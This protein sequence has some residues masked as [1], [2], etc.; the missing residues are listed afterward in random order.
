MRIVG[1]FVLLTM[2][3]A[4]RPSRVVNK[5]LFSTRFQCCGIQRWKSIISTRHQW[6][7]CDVTAAA[8]ADR[9][10]I[11]HQLRLTTHH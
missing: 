1:A 11:P 5:L 8:A 7:W 10:I 9:L 4:G 6:H 3:Q 2:Q